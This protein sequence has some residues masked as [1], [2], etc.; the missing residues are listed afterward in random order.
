[1]KRNG[2]ANLL[3]EFVKENDWTLKALVSGYVPLIFWKFL[4]PESYY[5]SKYATMADFLFYFMLPTIFVIMI[6]DFL[7][8]K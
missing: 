8:K 3:R 5:A 7:K 1:M 6:Y 2:I 4:M